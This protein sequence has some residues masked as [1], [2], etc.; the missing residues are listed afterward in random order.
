MQTDCAQSPVHHILFMLGL[1]QEYHALH[2][3]FN[4]KL[5]RT[6]VNIHQ[7]QV[8]QQK[9][10]DEIIL[11]KPLLICYQKILDLETGN[12]THHIDIITVA[13][14]SRIYSS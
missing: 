11:V 12:F 4:M 8:V 10:L 3:G 9:I 5:F 14:A 7:K 13:Y 2:I 6:V 1:N